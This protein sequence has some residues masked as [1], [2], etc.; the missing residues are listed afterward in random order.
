MADRFEFSAVDAVSDVS[1][2]GAFGFA[3]GDILIINDGPSNVHF[4]ISESRVATTSKMYLRP[5]ET[6]AKHGITRIQGIPPIEGAAFI[7]AEGESSSV[8]IGAWQ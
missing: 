6:W 3:A 1:Q 8:R 4:T 7:C 5:G 2:P